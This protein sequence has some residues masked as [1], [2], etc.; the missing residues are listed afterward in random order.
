MENLP[1][2]KENILVKYQNGSTGIKLIEVRRTMLE[3][4]EV[5]KALN[6]IEKVVFSASTKTLVSEIKDDV[7]VEKL[8]QLFRFIAVD[9]GYIIASESDW[10]YTCTRLFTFIKSYYHQLTLAD[11]KLAFELL[12][13]GE[14][15]EYLPKNRFGKPEKEHFQQFNVSYFG[16]VLNAYKEKRAE[17]ISKA[18]KAVPLI[19]QN[20]SSLEKK[21]Y[22]ND[23]LE[24]CKAYFLKYKYKGILFNDGLIEM[25]V[26]NWLI[27]VGLSH[28]V[29]ATNQDRKRALDIYVNNLKKANFSRDVIKNV[30]SRGIKSKEINHTVFEI[31]RNREILRVFRLL[32]KNW[33]FIDNY[34]DFKK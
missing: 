15:D 21:K 17:T 8:K 32:I 16:K 24:L 28:P 5:S 2:K 18:M 1:Q 10:V 30:Q 3:I 29:K 27:R 9:V 11:I 31:V 34:L 7:L 23:E 12:S 25:Y 26:Y 14:L 20:V 33:V 6:Q 19:E 22:H 13:T 4:P